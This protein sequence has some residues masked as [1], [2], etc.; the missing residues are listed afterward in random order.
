MNAIKGGEMTNPPAPRHGKYAQPRILSRSGS[1]QG[2]GFR[3]QRTIKMVN[4][5]RIRMHI[6]CH[7]HLPLLSHQLPQERAS[8]CACKHADD[9]GRESDR[10]SSGALSGGGGRPNTPS[11][12]T[13]H[14]TLAVTTRHRA[15]TAVKG[16]IR[17]LTPS[18]PTEI[19]IEISRSSS[20]SRQKNRWNTMSLRLPFE[21]QRRT[22]LRGANNIDI[23][24][25]NDSK[26]LSV[27]SPKSSSGF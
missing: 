22:T 17:L 25:D 20:R 13:M 10:D 8:P 23:D 1:K 15:D 19:W 9:C 16:C 27:P 7:E 14:T 21:R 24:N 4:H 26:F 11:L 5:N 2:G 3:R 6:I 18:S 12:S